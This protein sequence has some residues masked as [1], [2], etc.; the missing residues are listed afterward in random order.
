MISNTRDLIYD[1]YYKIFSSYSLD[2]HRK[3]IQEE[4]TPAINLF[5]NTYSDVIVDR[6]Q[7][8]PTANNSLELLI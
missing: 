7:L 1:V 2:F 3:Y 4:T 8:T 5:L 6:I